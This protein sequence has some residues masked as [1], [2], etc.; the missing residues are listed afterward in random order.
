MKKFALY[1]T[2]IAATV[3]VTYVALN[4]ETLEQIKEFLVQLMNK[5][6]ELF[7]NSKDALPSDEF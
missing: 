7:Q 5:I 1:A 6:S 3:G 4:P 2:L